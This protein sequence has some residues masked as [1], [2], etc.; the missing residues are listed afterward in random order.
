VSQ[1]L[2]EY[3]MDDAGNI[4]GVRMTDRGRRILKASKPPRKAI[5]VRVGRFIPREGA[6]PRPGKAG[7]GQQAVAHI[8]RRRA[9]Q[10]SLAAGAAGRA[11]RR[12]WQRLRRRPR[13]R[14]SVPALNRLRIPGVFGIAIAVVAEGAILADRI[15]TM[16]SAGGGM[17]PPGPPVPPSVV[18]GFIDDAGDFLRRYG[19]ERMMEMM[20]NAVQA[21]ANP[22][23]PTIAVDHQAFADDLKNFRSGLDAT[24]VTLLRQQ[25]AQV[26]RRC[27]EYTPP[28]SG[29]RQSKMQDRPGAYGGTARR[30]GERA[31]ERD[32]RRVF[33]PVNKLWAFMRNKDFQKAVRK[34]D[35]VAIRLILG[36]KFNFPVVS[37]YPLTSFHMKQRDRRGRVRKKPDQQLVTRPANLDR[38]VK[39][40]KHMVGYAKSGWAAAVKLFGMG[41]RG[42]G[43]ARTLPGWVSE[44]NGKGRGVDG[45]MM[46]RDPMKMWT[47]ISNEVPYIQYKEREV[48]IVSRAVDDQRKAFRSNLK[49]ILDAA[50]AKK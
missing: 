3:D 30:R 47:V 27:V 8:K 46:S 32:I 16:V 21:A 14:V 28:Y 23:V 13:P 6:G 50:G 45:T 1:A 35:A 17:R 37:P 4:T 38:Y 5:R 24:L 20:E 9:F 19:A 40:R 15:L 11:G 44:H 41:E 48:R 10:R 2:Y 12:N 25:T 29:S 33:V 31:A 43:Q 36:P 26:L 22:P 39:R 49:R 18:S 34:N 7:A 42:G